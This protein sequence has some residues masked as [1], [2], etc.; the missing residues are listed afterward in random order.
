MIH[1]LNP[2]S[3]LLLILLLPFG[4]LLF[5]RGARAQQSE[6]CG[7]FYR[8]DSFAARAIDK[9]PVIKVKDVDAHH[10]ALLYEEGYKQR[11][12]LDVYKTPEGLHLLAYIKPGDLIKKKAS[13]NTVLVIRKFNE[14][15]DVQVFDLGCSP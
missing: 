9:R 3:R 8:T 4:A 12:T 14:S 6:A 13:E 7:Q 10:F 15:L 2:V 1:P 11:K 5:P